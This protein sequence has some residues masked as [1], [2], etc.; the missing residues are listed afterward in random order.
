MAGPNTIPCDAVFSMR[1]FDI[2]EIEL[3]AARFMAL[4]GPAE[5]GSV[6]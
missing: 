5:N 2:A 1:K 4:V 3:A 6:G